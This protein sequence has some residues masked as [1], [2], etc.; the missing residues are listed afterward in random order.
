MAADWSKVCLC[1]SSGG[2]GGCAVPELVFAR[3]SRMVD[4]ADM[5]EGTACISSM[6]SPA[7]KICCSKKGIFPDSMACMSIFTAAAT[8]VP[9][10]HLRQLMQRKTH[11][12]GA[13]GLRL[14]ASCSPI[15]PSSASISCRVIM[16]FW[17]KALTMCGQLGLM[18]A[19]SCASKAHSC[20][21]L[22]TSTKFGSKQG[23]AV[24]V[25]STQR[26]AARVMVLFISPKRRAPTQGPAATIAAAENS[27]AWT[28]E[29]S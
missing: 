26:M 16:P 2:R 1:W 10:A 18:M 19:E 15:S 12:A 3:N 20:P 22:I 27:K 4:T 21:S 7:L 25:R 24:R 5:A 6:R 8:C 9:V 29:L 11:S 13:E 14:Q 17:S 28:K 23:A